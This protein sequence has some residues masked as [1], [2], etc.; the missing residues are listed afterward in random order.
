MKENIKWPRTAGP[1]YFKSS[2]SPR[3]QIDFKKKM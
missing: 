1:A 2:E 3:S